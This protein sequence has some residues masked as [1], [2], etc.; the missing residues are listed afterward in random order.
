[1]PH[2]GDAHALITARSAGGPPD[3]RGALAHARSPDLVRWEIEPPIVGP[4]EFGEIEVPQLV[5]A[6]DRWHL[7]F[8][9]PPIA[10]G[11]RWR[12]H[13]DRSPH[14]TVYHLTGETPLGPFTGPPE[15]VTV[16]DQDEALYAGKLVDDGTGGWVYL[17]ARLSRPDGT[18]AGE[19]TDPRP[20]TLDPA[21][22]LVIGA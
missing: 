19:L 4:G 13:T 10:H 22:H 8:S 11:T 21:G 17:A 6:N 12:R 18:F 7:L 9:V 16:S 14:P 2:R 20:V 3:G 15:P 1:L 5:G